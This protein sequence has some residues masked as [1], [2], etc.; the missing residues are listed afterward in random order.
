M[1]QVNVIEAKELLLGVDE[2]VEL[3]QAMGTPLDRSGSERLHK[4]VGGWI[5]LIR[6]A[7]TGAEDVGV[8]PVGIEEYLRTKVL[9]DIG[10]EALMAQLMR[11]S[12]AEPVSW[13]LFRDLCDDS[14][15]SR[16]LDAMEATGLMERVNGAKEVL[17]TIPA[18]VR[19]VLRDQYASS[20]VAVGTATANGS[21]VVRF[22]DD[23]VFVVASPATKAQ[24]T[25]RVTSTSGVVGTPLTLAMRGG[26]GTGAV[27]YVVT[28][29]TAS[30]CSIKAN[31]LSATSAGTCLVTATKAADA[32][33]SAISS[34]RTT[35]SLSLP[36]RP[37][38]LSLNFAAGKSSLSAGEKRALVSLSHK[39]LAGASVTITGYAK[40]NRVLALS[41]ARVVANF[42][43]SLVK[44]HVTLAT[45]ISTAVNKVTVRTVKQ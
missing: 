4:A 26:S 25:L 12:L 35:V 38:T 2:I 16:L 13:Q 31:A 45:S 22:S 6:M 27:S 34:V 40:A 28:N 39:L 33:Y 41:R 8:G 42:L 17:F 37:A 14:E 36:A 5:S 44:L 32:N 18:P 7:L 24:A 23:P 15:P 1:M 20:A 30:R 19:A 11:F 10:D 29:G 9:S 3:A 21:A 43:S